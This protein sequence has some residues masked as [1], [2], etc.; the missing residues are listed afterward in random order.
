MEKPLLALKSI[1][2]SSEGTT[3]NPTLPTDLS[4]LRDEKS[5]H[6]L[7]TPK[8]VL[9]QLTQMETAALFPDPALPPG[10]PFPWLGHVRQT[11]ASS[12]PMLISQITPAIF[13]EALR[14]TPNHKAAGPYGVPGVVLKYMPTTFNE[15]LHVLF[16]ALAIT[17]V[18]SPPSLL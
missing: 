17:G 4:I 7:T 14:R 15:A 16:Q 18:T 5:G 11:P 3:D 8:E 2:R 10:A 9:T 1:L 12:V 6:L 13:K